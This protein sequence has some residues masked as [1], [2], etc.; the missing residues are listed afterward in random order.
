MAE[1]V[2]VGIFELFVFRVAGNPNPDGRTDYFVQIVVPPEFQ[3]NAESWVEAAACLTGYVA[4]HSNFGYEKSLEIITERAMSYRDNIS[5]NP[6]VSPNPTIPED[7][8][9]PANNNPDF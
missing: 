2:P 4:R 1:L 6:P 5:P 3:D 7:P 8:G 9:N